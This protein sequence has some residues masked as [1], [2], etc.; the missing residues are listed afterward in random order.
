MDTSFAPGERGAHHS[1]LHSL[2]SLHS[3]PSSF[4]QALRR[5]RA[6][7]VAKI[8]MSVWYRIPSGSASAPTGA[9]SSG[10]AQSRL[11]R[12]GAPPR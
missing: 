12:V 1:V 3:S 11:R 5:A 7:T 10:R 9:S 8:L 6:S 2:L 4:W